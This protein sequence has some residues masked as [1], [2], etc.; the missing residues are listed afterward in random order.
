M[1][2]GKTYRVWET[3]V[4]K[5]LSSLAKWELTL[6]HG[7]RAPSGFQLNI[8]ILD[9]HWRSWYE[10]TLVSLCTIKDACMRTGGVMNIDI[11]N[12]RSAVESDRKYNTAPEEKKRFKK[13][14]TGRAC[15]ENEAWGWSF[16]SGENCKKANGH[17]DHGGANSKMQNLSLRRL[18]LAIKQKQT[19]T[20]E[21][22]DLKNWILNIFETAENF[23]WRLC[24]KKSEKHEF[25]SMEIAGNSTGMHACQQQSFIWNFFR[26]WYYWA[27][28]KGSSVSFKK[29]IGHKRG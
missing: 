27:L 11:T 23:C 5:C 21:L 28:I 8:S 14:G 1:D 10:Q 3:P 13:E 29:G 7:I 26:Q 18:S 12:V 17:W 15:H 19:I 24:H 16:C 9:V 4:H 6:S 2:I 25:L 22:E 20:K